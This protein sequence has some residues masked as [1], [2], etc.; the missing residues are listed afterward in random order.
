MELVFNEMSFLPYSE[1]DA[2]LKECFIQMLK[3]YDKTKTEM[4]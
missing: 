1:N 2:I 3:L 4:V